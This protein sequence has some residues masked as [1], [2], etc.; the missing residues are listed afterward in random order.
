MN[1][2]YICWLFKHI[3]LGILIFKWLTAR[4]LCKSFGVKGLKRLQ[5]VDLILRFSIALTKYD[6]YIYIYMCVCVCEREKQMRF[7]NTKYYVTLI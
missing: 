1:N 2:W 7:Q 6:I 5:V 4:R 3:F